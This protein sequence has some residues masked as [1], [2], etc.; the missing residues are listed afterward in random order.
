MQRYNIAFYPH[1]QDFASHCVSFAVSNFFDAAD[2]YL[3]DGVTAHPHVTLCQFEAEE[4]QLPDI[5]NRALQI[6]APKRML[7][8]GE[9]FIQERPNHIW[10]GLEIIKTPELEREQAELVKMLAG[11]GIKTFTKPGADYFSHLTFASLIEVPERMMRSAVTGAEQPFFLSLGRTG[12]NGV[13]Q[14]IIF[15]E[16]GPA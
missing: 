16:A 1:Q 10:A 4:D 11:Q 5:W 6:C 13:Y 3:L 15:P 12:E 7:K 2:D 14:R 9:L 8:L